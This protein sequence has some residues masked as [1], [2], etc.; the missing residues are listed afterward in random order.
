MLDTNCTSCHGSATATDGIDL[1][2]YTKVKA[3]A[4]LANTEIQSGAM[5]PGGG[6]STADKQMFQSWVSAGEPDN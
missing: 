2:S 6:L 5:P 3:N 1:S 4:A